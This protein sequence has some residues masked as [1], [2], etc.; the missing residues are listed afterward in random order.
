MEKGEKE[1]R[2]VFGIVGE[3]EDMAM[4][5]VDIAI[6]TLGSLFAQ[7]FRL[8]S[9]LR[10][11]VAELRDDLDFMRYFLQDAENQS[12]NNPGVRTWVKQVRDLAY[13]AEDAVDEFFFTFSSLPRTQPLIRYF[14]SISRLRAQR[15]LALQIKS[16]NFRI[17]AI[18]QRRHAFSIQ[19]LIGSKSTTQDGFDPR[20]AALYIDE[21]DI[22]GIDNPRTTLIKWLVE[23]KEQLT[24]L[25]V[26]GMGGVGKTTLVKKVFD[27]QIVTNWFDCQSWVT[28][29]KSFTL[30][31]LL[32]AMLKRFVEKS[33]DPAYKDIKQMTKSQL[34]DGLRAYLQ[35]KRYVVVLDDIWSIADWEAVRFALLECNCRSRIIITTRFVEVANSMESDGHIYQLDPLPDEEAWTLF[36][37]KTFRG[38]CGGFLSP[39]IGRIIS[40]ILE[41]VWRTS[42][43]N[44]SNKRFAFDQ[45]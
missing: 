45:K 21:A 27:S 44:C 18:S 38:H 23:G 29:S 19:R 42:T 37:L 25:P 12:Q 20:Q 8:I 26:V 40:C 7:E 17:A 34:V 41:E 3:P 1:R 39:R 22:V 28:V 31:E 33:K 2:L 15:R 11:A 16:I 36:C 32:Q 13:D 5:P 10:Q 35:Q 6:Q 24:C 30:L 4:I 43:C 14:R 9:G